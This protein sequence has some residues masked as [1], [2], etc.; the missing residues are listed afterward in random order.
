MKLFPVALA[1]LV[2]SAGSVAAQGDIDCAN[3]LA[4]SDMNI[5]AERDFEAA[6]KELNAIW[7]K[8]REAA[9][10]EDAQ[11]PEDLKGA[12]AAL[13]AGQRGWLAY[14]D[15]QCKLAGFE[16]RG[17]SLEPMLISGCMADLTRRRIEEL[18]EYVSGPGQ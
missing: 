11:Q 10:A 16:A 13:V 7:K 4:Q 17:G 12:D 9:Q 18:K 2:S 6:D 1:L 8:A 14:R 3:A 5:C 15:G